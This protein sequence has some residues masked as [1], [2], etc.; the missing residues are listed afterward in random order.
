V[1][2]LPSPTPPPRSGGK[3][4][5]SSGVSTANVIKSDI[6]AGNAVIHLIDNV[7]APVA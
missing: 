5:V 2:L 1:S 6:M 3:L 4:T 7:L